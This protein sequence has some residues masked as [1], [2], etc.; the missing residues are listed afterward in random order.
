MSATTTAAPTRAAARPLSF[1]ERL[2]LTGLA[3]DDRLAGAGLELDVRTAPIEIPEILVAPQLAAAPRPTT[4]DEVRA[5]AARLIRTHGW[6]PR[7]LGN[8]DTGYC[9]I[10][11]IRAAAG[12][13][14]PLADEACDVVFKRIRRECPDALSIGGWNT[15]QSGPAPVIRML[16]G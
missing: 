12:G 5:E 4:V 3:M 11:A 16:G 10:G 9:L 7:Y 1:D 15:A 6:N 14:N 13:D 8:A 2:A